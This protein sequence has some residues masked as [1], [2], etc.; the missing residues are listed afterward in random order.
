MKKAKEHYSYSIYRD[1]QV[2]KN[3]DAEKFGSEVGQLIL[4][5]Q[6]EQI[7]SM[8]K[9]FDISQCSILDVGTGT[10][11]MLEPLFLKN[12]KLVGCDASFEMLSEAKNKIIGKSLKGIFLVQGDGISLP[13][14]D[15]SFDGIISLRTLMHIVDWKSA[16]MEF[17]R[18][19]RDFLIIDFPPT[20]SLVAI[21]PPILH[22][23]KLFN[24][25]TQTYRVI[26]INKVK[27]L[28]ASFGFEIR[29]K[30]R[31]FALPFFL[32]RK[33]N[34]AKFTLKIENFFKDLKLTKLI[35]S[36]LTIK[37]VRINK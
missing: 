2:A 37:A 10:G 16:L 1:K 5:L 17:C 36:P 26:S 8:L 31:Q 23:K 11:R 29:Y 15:R 27:R 22:F 14:K 12:A 19:A 35:G 21:H 25:N 24:Q 6:E 3:F 7:L 32:H 13:F 33:I 34:N 30:W 9:E 28:L 18:V 20:T 4:K